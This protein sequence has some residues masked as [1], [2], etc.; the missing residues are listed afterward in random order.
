VPCRDK[1]DFF[2]MEEIQDGDTC[3]SGL[4]TSTST[5]HTLPRELTTEV[6][7]KYFKIKS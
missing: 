7:F 3:Y 6:V 1:D 5:H 4:V 2:T